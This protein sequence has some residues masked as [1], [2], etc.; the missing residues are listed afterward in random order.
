MM[1]LGLRKVENICCGHKMFLNKIRNLFCVRNK[2]CACR[3]TGKHLCQQQCV[4]NN[5]SSLARAF[6]V[7]WVVF[8]REINI[9]VS[10][11]IVVRA[12]MS[13]ENC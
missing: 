13:M 7:T 8:A 4:R 9:D 11:A 2:S 10:Q 3:Q 12:I 1:F 5:V 6:R